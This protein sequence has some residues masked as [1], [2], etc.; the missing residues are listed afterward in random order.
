ML[1]TVFL[2][3]FFLNEVCKKYY[4]NQYNQLSYLLSYIIINNYVNIK[5][6]MEP[7]I[8]Q[9]TYN[10]IYVYSVLQINLIKLQKIIKPYLNK[11][12]LSD[13]DEQ[14]YKTTIAFYFNGNLIKEHKF[15]FKCNQLFISNIEQPN[16]YDLVSIIDHN[17]EDNMN[18]L[19][20]DT[21]QEI[22]FSKSDIK[23]IS[24]ECN[25]KN[26]IYEINLKTDKYNFYINETI[27]NK[28]FIKYYLKNIL[29]HN[30][31]FENDDEFKYTLNLIDNNV[32]IVFLNDNDYI[33]IQKDNYYIKSYINTN[34]NETIDLDLNSSTDIS[35]NKSDDFVKLNKN[36]NLE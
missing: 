10:S 27:I 29:N 6:F 24:L 1:I 19:L 8:I 12:K 36:D 22:K 4:P 11:L 9:L 33:I 34:V 17:D 21:F 30:I 3:G 7:K 26:Q 23:F 5:A 2:W 18:I 13:D 14:K 32:N 20:L 35:S 31:N 25:Y 28:Q 15:N 16:M